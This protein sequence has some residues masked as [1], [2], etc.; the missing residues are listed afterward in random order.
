MDYFE[1]NHG[2]GVADGIGGT[3]KH[4]V[5]SHVLTKRVVIKSPKQFAEYANK[6]LPKITDQYVDNESMELGYQSECQ[7]KAKKVK[8]TLKVHCVKRLMQNSSC[9]L[10]FF[11]ASKSHNSLAEVQYQVGLLTQQV[12]Y[13]IETYVLIQYEGELWPRQITK[14]EQDRMRVKCFQKAAAQGSIWR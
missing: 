11:M 3:V 9:Q 1:V 14:A 10:K 8:E 13:N 7:E 5:Y 6:I 12:S 2:K 4:V